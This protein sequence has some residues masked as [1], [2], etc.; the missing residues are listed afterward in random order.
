[1][2]LLS[3]T[4]EA[5]AATLNMHTIQDPLLPFSVII[6][7]VPT[8]SVTPTSKSSSVFGGPLV[9]VFLG[10]VALLL[11]LMVIGCVVLCSWSRRNKYHV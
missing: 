1:M 11:V 4:L 7:E 10:V 9:G 5:V 2:T 8:T 6:I 3:F